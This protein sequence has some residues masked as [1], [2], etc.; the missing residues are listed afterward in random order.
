MNYTINNKDENC[1]IVIENT[2]ECDGVTFLDIKLN[3]EK[4]QVPSSFSL[5]WKFINANN[6]GSGI[7]KRIEQR[8][9]RSAYL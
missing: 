4:E 6:Y 1:S 2:R 9:R 8:P 5:K 7:E 3:Y